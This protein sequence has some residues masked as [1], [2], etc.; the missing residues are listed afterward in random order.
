MS[1]KHQLRIMRAAFPECAVTR[2]WHLCGAGPARFGWAATHHAS[3]GSQ[4]N[5]ENSNG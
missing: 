3:I 2:G 1:P 4:Q 5:Q